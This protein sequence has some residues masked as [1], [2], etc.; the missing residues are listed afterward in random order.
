VLGRLEQLISEQLGRYSFLTFGR[1]VY[2]VEGFEEGF[3]SWV[4]ACA[5]LD[6][7]GAQ[8]EIVPKRRSQTACGSF[9]SFRDQ[10][11][12]MSAFQLS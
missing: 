1:R 8:L 11:L 7:N 4:E 5:A 9:D 6:V 10:W 2:I 12:L 3:D